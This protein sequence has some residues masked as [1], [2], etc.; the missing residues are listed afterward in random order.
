MQMSDFKHFLDNE[1][2]REQLGIALLFC[3]LLLG[4]FVFFFPSKQEEAVATAT[5]TPPAPDAYA[6]VKLEGKAAI[7]YDLTTGLPLYE[8]N[9]DAQLPLASLTKL[10]TTYAAVDTL[11]PSTTI[12]MTPNAIAQDGDSGLMEGEQFAFKDIARLAL[13]A[14]SNDAAEAI[15]EA[16][17]AS[18][19]ES[20][21]TLLKNAAAAAALSQTY[22]INGTGL[23]END[24]VSGGYGSARDVAR[25]ASALLEKAPDIARATT[26]PTVTADSLSGT[27]HTLP[28][29]DIAIGHFPSPLLSK[30]GFTDLAGGNL[31]V[32]F[33]AGLDH[34][35]A[36]VVLGSTRDARFTDVDTLISATL[37]HFA[38]VSPNAP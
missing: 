11:S 27:V 13:V 21:Q 18:R 7:V 35:I 37:S 33:N 16:A 29:T 2:D 25:L 6:N 24:A 12:T 8:R 15:T 23:D 36:V 38:G 19:A 22:A 5:T 14:S 4:G 17:S 1:R 30:T 31:A 3:A 28:N 32:I 26:E 34:P 9:A 20:T 10:L